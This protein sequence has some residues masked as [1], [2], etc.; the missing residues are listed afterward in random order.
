MC[1][2]NRCKPGLS[3]TS[4]DMW[5]P[6]VTDHLELSRKICTAVIKIPTF[7]QKMLSSLPKVFIHRHNFR[8]IRFLVFPDIRVFPATLMVL[9]AH[10]N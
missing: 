8:A 9:N 5:S 7:K 10:H 3:L 6:Y 1:R 2:D 4:R